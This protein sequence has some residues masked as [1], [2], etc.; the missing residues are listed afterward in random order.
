[1]LYSLPAALVTSRTVAKRRRSDR[2][3]GDASSPVF[4]AYSALTSHCPEAGPAGERQADRMVP[5]Q[6]RK[7][8]EAVVKAQKKRRRERFCKKSKAEIRVWLKTPEG[9][10]WLERKI[11]EK[12]ARK[13]ARKT[14]EDIAAIRRV[15]LRLECSKC[16]H[17]IG[18][19]CQLDL[20][21]GCL[22]YLEVSTLRTATD[23]LDEKKE[24]Q[25]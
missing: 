16:L 11:Q 3:T 17:A 20:P 8:G 1:M 7:K 13:N 23:I 2:Y 21:N 19:H 15:G 24:A 9:K 18:H 10:D 6:R 5:K 12:C 4:R 14:R 25:K 22:D